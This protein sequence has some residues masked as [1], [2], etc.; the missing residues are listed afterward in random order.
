MTTILSNLTPGSSSST[1]D[2][3]PDWAAKVDAHAQA[4]SKKIAGPLASFFSDAGGHTPEAEKANKEL[5]DIS[6]HAAFAGLSNYKHASDS[7]EELRW[8]TGT[9]TLIQE[10]WSNTFSY[11]EGFKVGL[12][13][14]I[15][16]TTQSVIAV[17]G[18]M[19]GKWQHAAAILYTQSLDI[20][21]DFFQKT[22]N[23]LDQVR[24]A[25]AELKAGKW[26]VIEKG[27]D[28]VDGYYKEA[29]EKIEYLHS[30]E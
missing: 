13:K 14:A 10:D 21:V 24:A 22:A 19:P 8:H 16:D 25:Q 6:L 1:K 9:A 12:E 11:G 15:Q 3:N 17:I 4:A 27:K 30:H 5:K 23:A 2:S 7:I 18:P 26:G 20:L 29:V 28:A